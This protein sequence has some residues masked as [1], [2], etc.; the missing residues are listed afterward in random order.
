MFRGFQATTKQRREVLSRLHLNFYDKAGNFV[1]MPTA[2][3]EM[4]STFIP[5]RAQERQQYMYELFRRGGTLAADMLIAPEKKGA[6]TWADIATKSDAATTLAERNRIKNRTLNMKSAELS[7]TNV[8]TA[9]ILFEPLLRPLTRFVGELNAASGSVSKYA[10]KHNAVSAAVSYGGAAITSAAGVYGIYHLIKAIRPGTRVLRGLFGRMGSSAAGIVEG[11]AI[12]A[13]TGVQPVFVTNQPPSMQT[14]TAAA[15]ALATTRLRTVSGLKGLLGATFSLRGGFMAATK[16]L[17]LLG[18]AAGAGALVGHEIYKH[19]I[20]GSAL[21]HAMYS[22]ADREGAWFHMGRGW[23]LEQAKRKGER[24]NR[25][26]YARME[27][28]RVDVH[29]HVAQDGTVRVHKLTTSHPNVQAHV[30]TALSTP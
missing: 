17:G 23:M 18:I 7:S 29:L 8:T 5:M 4:R 13:A 16:Q 28:A 14:G 11:K 21:E 25:G 1:G 9:G 19:A 26:H 12:Q 27:A 20:K 2:I 6:K 24:L 30:G 15:A 10:V 3:K 22:F